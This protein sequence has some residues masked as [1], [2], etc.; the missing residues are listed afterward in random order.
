MVEPYPSPAVRLSD[1]S[2][3]ARA[4]NLFSLRREFWSINGLVLGGCR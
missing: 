2:R 4:Y 3:F 1:T